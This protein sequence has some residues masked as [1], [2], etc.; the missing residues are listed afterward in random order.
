MQ[1]FIDSY[2]AFLHVKDNMF[3]VKLYQNNQTVKKKIAPSKIS[4][5]L[6]SKG[7][8]LSYEAVNMCLTYNIDLLFLEFDG[9]PI[10]RVWHSKLG[11]TTKI[12]KHQLVASVNEIG[13]KY[14]KEWIERKIANQIEFLKKLKKHRPNKAEYFNETIK[15]LKQS[16]K[17]VSQ[18]KGKN[19]KEVAESLRGYEG[20]AGRFYFEVLSNSLTKE[21]NFI[22]RSSRPAKDPFNSFLNYAFGV[23]YSKIEKALI[24]AGIDPYLG[25]LHRDDYNQKSMVFDFIEPYRIFAEEVV[26]KLFSAKKVNKKH[27]DEITNGFSLNKEGKILLMQSFNKFMDEDKVRYKGKNHTRNNIIQYDAHAFANYLI[28]KKMDYKEIEKY[29]LLGDV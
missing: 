15:K 27:T 21:N 9:T 14:V 12:R 24:I 13:V 1:L 29:D 11:S 17:G 18:L 26:F 6:L 4:T 20:S 8:S 7:T 10:G 22:G 19:I 23:L 16:K 2:G 28:N 25:F 5:I 3:E